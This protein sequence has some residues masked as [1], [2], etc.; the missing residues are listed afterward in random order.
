MTSTRYALAVFSVT[1]LLACSTYFTT[2]ESRENGT[3]I[4]Q[5]S[6]RQ[7]LEIAHRA[8]VEAFPS[9]NVTKLEGPTWGFSTTYRNFLDT[10]SQQVLVMP[11]EGLAPDGSRV[12]GVAFDVS[13]S[14]TTFISGQTKNRGLFKR[15][16]VLADATGTRVFVVNP[17][18]VSFRSEKA[19]P[20]ALGSTDVEDRLRNLRDLLDQ[21]LIT[22]DQFESKQQEI[23]DDL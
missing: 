2:A 11:L 3:L 14:G 10:Y 21:G 1:G 13:G 6:D 22:P 17:T 19:S 8:L 4:Y 18:P 9:R 15:V 5:I 7:A 16:R 20:S 12:R 23:L